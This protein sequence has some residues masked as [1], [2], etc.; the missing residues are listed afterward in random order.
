MLKLLIWNWRSGRSAALNLPEIVELKR[1]RFCI[2]AEASK[3]SQ[4][5]RKINSLNSS[6]ASVSE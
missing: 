6:T 2:A 4:E 5:T 3:A 1:R